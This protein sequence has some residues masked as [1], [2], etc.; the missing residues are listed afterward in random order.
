MIKA[1]G[2]FKGRETLFVGLSFGNLDKFRAEPL[3]T[4]ITIEG[5]EVGL[6]FDV[7]IFSGETEAQMTDAMAGSFGPDT[8]IHVS[9]KLKQ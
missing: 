3:D 9:P 6:P 8:K 7:M 4:F 2:K 1:T 5:R